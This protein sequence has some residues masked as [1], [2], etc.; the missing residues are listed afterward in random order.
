MSAGETPPVP[1][2]SL[3]DH[4]SRLL[5]WA[6]LVMMLVLLV[7]A[8]FAFNTRDLCAYMGTDYRGYY[9]SAQIALERGF[10]SVYDHDIQVEYQSL[11]SHPC[12]AESLPPME[13]VSMPYQ[14]VF[15]LLFLPMTAFGFTSGYV[16]WVA[17]NLGV[18]YIYLLRFSKALS[19][20]LT[21]FRLLQWLVCL[22]MI[23]N[24]Y[25]G[26]MNVF[27][28]VCLAEFTLALIKGQQLRSG[29]WLGGLLI[30]PHTL[31][32]LMPGLLLSRRWGVV[33]GFL[34][35]SLV[36]VGGSIAISGLDGV[37]SSLELAVSFAGPLIQTAS[38]MMNWRALALN[39]SGFIPDWIAWMMALA[40]MALVA[41]LVLYLWL[42][43]SRQPEVGVVLLVLATYAGTLTVAWHSH[44]YLLVPLIPLLV[45]LDGRKILSLNVR[46]AWLFG[47]P[48]WYMLVYVLDPSSARNWFGLGMLALSL[49]LLAWASVRL[50]NNPESL[51][52]RT[53]NHPEIMD[54][55]RI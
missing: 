50:I 2:T 9:T 53:Q 12:A 36:I 32:L 18:I 34:S 19:V 42:R 24:L 4:A 16:L 35:G 1:H 39:L 13:R 44:F 22:P 47:P 48:L 11:L 41:V 37:R 3:S 29:M 23:T 27:L 5:D 30:K 49:Y 33:R 17:L 46:L 45:F 51:T 31:V 14:P 43:R 52:T 55:Q 26:Q 6:W 40:G 15:V 28:M 25:L 20:S 54:I 7:L 21:T 10:A 8:M 38:T